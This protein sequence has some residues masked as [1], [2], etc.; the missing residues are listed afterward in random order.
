MVSEQ[1]LRAIAKG[2]IPMQHPGDDNYAN[3]VLDYIPKTG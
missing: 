1:L 3:T 2:K